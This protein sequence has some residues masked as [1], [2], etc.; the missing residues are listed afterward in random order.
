MAK[1]P[2]Q[3]TV[4]SR[5]DGKATW[6]RQTRYIATPSR[7]SASHQAGGHQHHFPPHKQMCQERLCG[8]I[9]CDV[10]IRI[11]MVCLIAHALMLT[12]DFAMCQVLSRTHNV[13]ARVNE[14][15]FPGD[16]AR[17]GAT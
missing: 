6:S 1:W 5:L 7:V 16:G 2:E 4:E 11:E 10:F 13:V 14:E 3:A 8:R 17:Q 9:M 12:Y 15:H